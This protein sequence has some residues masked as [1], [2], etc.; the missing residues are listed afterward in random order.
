MDEDGFCLVLKRGVHPVNR[1]RD[2]SVAL[3]GED[4]IDLLPRPDLVQILFIDQQIAMDLRVVHDFEQR[5]GRLG[6]RADFGGDV[7]DR[8]ANRGAQGDLRGEIARQRLFRADAELF[9]L[10][11]EG[12]DFGFLDPEI[13]LGLL[14][15]LA[16]PGVVLREVALPLVLLFGVREAVFEG[17]V[18][19]LQFQ[20]VGVFECGEDLSLADRRAFLHADLADDP[21]HERRQLGF[22]LW[23]HFQLP[24]RPDDRAE[25]FLL[26]RAEG[27]ADG[28]HL[29]G[30][31]FERASGFLVV[32]GF[33]GFAVIVTVAGFVFAASEKHGCERGEAGG[34]EKFML[35]N[36]VIFEFG[37]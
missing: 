2:W 16:R 13:R 33:G 7:A 9:E 32:F 10:F 27:D 4:E 37:K 12:G 25:V 34:F 31:Q 23:R 35:K 28:F 6:E 14:E 18:V 19:L 22:V 30:G 1:A 17:N 3:I 24:V 11:F 15:N 5:A 29:F 21:A 26:D 20:K 8:A 36:H